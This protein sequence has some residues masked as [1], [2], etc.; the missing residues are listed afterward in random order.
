MAEP[1]KQGDEDRQPVWRANDEIGACFERLAALV[2]TR[3]PLDV[4]TRLRLHINELFIALRE[5]LEE[6]KVALDPH[7]TSTQRTVELFLSGLP[8]HLEHP[9]T[10]PEM[11]R[12]CGLSIS[13]FTQYCGRITNLTPTKYLVHCR[14]EE[15][16]RLL[17]M[18]P[19]L[20][21][22]DIAFTCGFQSSQYQATV[23]R[24][25]TGRSPRA[26]REAPSPTTPP[27]PSA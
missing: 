23:F 27:K 10:L 1:S 7:L 9:W 3:N 17:A 11:A 19:D 5:L 20:S 18:Q 4:Q 13:A 6:E 24:Q 15:A 22:T 16:K 12:Q 26:W 14:V 21:I 25:K 2:Q 8:R